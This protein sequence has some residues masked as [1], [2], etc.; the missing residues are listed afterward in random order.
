MSH[1]QPSVPLQGRSTEN[2]QSR[3]A[4]GLGCGRPVGGRT[5][6]ASHWGAA[7]L[8]KPRHSPSLAETWESMPPA[9]AHGPLGPVMP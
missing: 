1:A 9:Q 5:S 2:T 6:Q 8:Q 7:S 3:T 4:G